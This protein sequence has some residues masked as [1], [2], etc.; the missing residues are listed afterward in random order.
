MN[1]LEYESYQ[2]NRKH[3]E[4]LFPYDVYPYRIPDIFSYVP[5]HWHEEIEILF[6]EKGQ[7]LVTVNLKQYQVFAGS[8]ILIL[9][10]QL[11][12]IA[13]DKDACMEYKAIIFHPNLLISRQ[14]DICTSDYIQPILDGII[15]VPTH[16]VP[17][18]PHYPELVSFLGNCVQIFQ[19]KKEGYP[20]FI[21]GQLYLLFFTLIQNFRQSE[22]PASNTR[23]LE[24]MKPVLKYVELHY[25]EPISIKTAADIAA[26]S[27]SHFMRCFKE[28]FGSSFVEYLKDFRLT[29]AARMLTGSD[30]SILTIAAETGFENLSYFNRSFKNKFGTTPGQYRKNQ[31]FSSH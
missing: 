15:S 12:S 23:L 30:N 13:Q 3:G 24:R 27:S 11:H 26:C 29:M 16:F 2:E 28:A 1:I 8:V 18:H 4:L 25:A 6:I 9:P 5:L 21:K 10:G 14:K 20:L 7:G 17:A 19:E 31:K 22:A